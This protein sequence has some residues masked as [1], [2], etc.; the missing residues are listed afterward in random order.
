[1]DT[2]CPQCGRRTPYRGSFCI[3]CGARLRQPAESSAVPAETESPQRKAALAAVR[4]SAFL[5]AGVLLVV[6]AQYV[7]ITTDTTDRSPPLTGAGALIAGILVFAL[8]SYL[9]HARQPERAASLSHTPADI[10]LAMP[11][12]PVLVW[13]AGALMVF[14]LIFRLLT[15]SQSPWD[16]LPWALALGA[17]ALP[18]LPNL[19]LPEWRG[20]MQAFQRIRYDM[21]IVAGFVVFFIA[22]N[23]RDLN[24]WYYSIIGDE[25]VFWE[26]ARIIL[27]NGLF[28]PFDQ[29]GVHQEHPV[30]NVAFKSFVM[31]FAGQN[32]FGI[33]FSSV[34]AGAASIPGVYLLAHAVGRGRTAAIIATALFSFSHYIFAFV[35]IQYISVD[36]MI[37][38]VYAFGFLVLA[39]G[40][41]ARS[42]CISRES[43]R[44]LV[45]T[46]SSLPA[47]SCPSS[48][49]SCSSLRAPTRRCSTPGLSSSVSSQPR[50]LPS[51]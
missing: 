31:L 22:I 20:A 50:C 19:R 7:F 40:N 8:G 35:H 15:G 44:G 6:L 2:L 5:V 24:A 11:S 28:R 48:C 29:A 36:G 21:L 33:T 4:P 41:A 25:Y 47:R 10:P 9:Y 51:S 49:C 17:F 12:R 43:R 14:W 23:A 30:L 42:S 27:D 3:E 18:F 13:V 45:S 26:N 38:A 37:P 34:L 39:S 46:R 16:L 1:M 32:H